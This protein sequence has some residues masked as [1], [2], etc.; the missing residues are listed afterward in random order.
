METNESSEGRS[1]KEAHIWPRIG[2]GAIG[3]IF[4]LLGLAQMVAGRAHGK[5]A[6]AA[7]ERRTEPVVFWIYI[8]AHFVIAMFAVAAAFKGSFERDDTNA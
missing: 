1:A 6:I 2:I 7:V 5:Y 3:L 8:A 4:A